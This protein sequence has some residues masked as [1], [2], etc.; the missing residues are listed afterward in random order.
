MKEVQSQG[1]KFTSTSSVLWVLS[2][3]LTDLIR[4]LI[5]SRR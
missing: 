5:V 2:E 3:A 1:H 4:E